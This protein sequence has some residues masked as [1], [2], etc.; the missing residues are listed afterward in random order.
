MVADRLSGPFRKALEQEGGT[1]A[2][3]APG[4]RLV[5]GLAHPLCVLET[6]VCDDH[7]LR[8]FSRHMTTRPRDLFALLNEEERTIFRAVYQ[9]V[10]RFRADPA[11]ALR[12]A[13]AQEMTM[14][15]KELMDEML[16]DVPKEDLLKRLS[17]EE[18][19]RGLAP[20]ERMRGLAPEER[21]RGLSL[22]EREQLRKLLS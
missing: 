13:D 14:S 22:E 20:E 3:E 7:V 18:R 15:L 10:K 9:E 1:L 2:Q 19:M 12:Y 8:L 11:L 17:P 16:D 5:S 6:A 4:I 21:L